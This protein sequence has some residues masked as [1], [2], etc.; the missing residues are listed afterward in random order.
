MDWISSQK[1][2]ELLNW[3]TLDCAIKWAKK[4][5][6]NYFRKG[7]GY[8]GRY[9]F[10][11]KEVLVKLDEMNKIV[12]AREARNILG[13]SQTTLYRWIRQGD[14]KPLGKGKRNTSLFKKTRIVRFKPKTRFWVPWQE[15]ALKIYYNKMGFFCDEIGKKLGKSPQ[16]V[17]SKASH[18]G[19]GRNNSREFYFLK[20][21]V[22]TLGTNRRRV[23]RWIK[24]GKLAAVPL[25][26]SGG[27]IRYRISEES[28]A[29][30]M[31]LYLKNQ[32][33]LKPLINFSGLREY[34]KLNNLKIPKG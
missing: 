12:T 32:K 25:V 5:G 29:R 26:S 6:I 10:D 13:I 30:L 17:T 34:S 2:A 22:E 4:E 7:G 9:W 31:I 11:K 3:K 20:D 19:L 18:L 27:R 14:I 23:S 28:I 1:L 16:A 21:V 24:S 8:L 15:K 33:G